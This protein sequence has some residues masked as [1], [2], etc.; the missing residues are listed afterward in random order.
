MGIRSLEAPALVRNALKYGSLFVLWV[1][2]T[3]FGLA[4]HCAN[5][6]VVNPC[7]PNPNLTGPPFVN[8]CPVPASALNGLVGGPKYINVVGLGADPTGVA[9]AAPYFRQ[10]A[11]LASGNTIYVPPG[12]YSMCSTVASGFATF[13]PAA[14]RVSGKSNFRIYAQGATLVPCN[15]LGLASL[16]QLDSVSNCEVLGGTFTGNHTGISYNQENAGIALLSVVDCTVRGQLFNGNWGGISTPF[17]GDFIVNGTFRDINMHNAGQCFDFAFLKNVT[18]DNVHADGADADGTNGANK[19]GRKC[20]SVIY[21][22]PNIGNNTTGYTIADTDGLVVTNSSASNFLLGW[23]LGSG[24]NYR[25]AGNLWESNVGC[26]TNQPALSNCLSAGTNKGYGGEITGSGTVP[27]QGFTSVAEVYNLNGNATFPGGGLLV[28]SSLITSTSIAGL[29]IEGSLFTNNTNLAIESTASPATKIGVVALNPVCALSASQTG[30]IGPNINSMSS[31]TANN[32][33]ISGFNNVPGSYF[34]GGNA[35]FGNGA[36]YLS[37]GD[38]V[39][40][41]GPPPTL[42]SGAGDCGTSPSFIGNNISGKITVGSGANGGICTLTFSAT[43]ANAPACSAWNETSGA[44]IAFGVSTGA[45]LKAK[46]VTTFTAADVLGY[47][48]VGYQ[49]KRPRGFGPH[50]QG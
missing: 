10:A 35:V 19:V 22:S 24:S 47:Q 29:S 27:V 41:G 48:C 7:V 28:D 15:A 4:P 34:L 42:G 14:V 50:G 44:R 45:T 26:T 31:A 23:F 32:A 3:L 12:T 21:D 39:F 5:A 43:F 49:L 16:I 30:C 40:Y 13:N 8:G 33:A 9:D 18:I 11:A 20:V 38:P 1:A 46:A 6:Q 25:F 37:A 2:V 17:A 36:S